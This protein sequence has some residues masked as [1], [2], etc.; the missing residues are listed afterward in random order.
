[1]QIN[2]LIYKKKLEIKLKRV[3]LS[4]TIYLTLIN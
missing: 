3:N 4:R 1:M 2:T